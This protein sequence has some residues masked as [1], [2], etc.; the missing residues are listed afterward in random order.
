MISKF[1]SGVK[2][3]P[4]VPYMSP[5]LTPKATPRFVSTAVSPKITSSATSPVK[6]RGETQVPFSPW[7]PSSQ[8]SSANNSPPRGRSLNGNSRLL[9]LYIDIKKGLFK[10]N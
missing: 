10:I 9:Y 2:K 1:I 6:T 3:Y 5:K 7:Y 8:L 4:M